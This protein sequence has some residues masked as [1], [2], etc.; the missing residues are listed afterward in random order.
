[1]AASVK[2][3]RMGLAADYLGMAVALV[4]LIAVFGVVAENFFTLTNFRT[5]ANQIPDVTVAAVGM[6]FVLIIAGIDLSVGSVLALSSAVLGMA[7]V[8][9]GLPLV[10][11]V[12]IC[13]LVLVTIGAISIP[14]L[15]IPFG[16]DF[17]F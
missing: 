14:F 1:M 15:C 10:P 12:G 13:L 6:T 11:A 7:L 8:N 17:N 2:K 3:R 5:I 9:W 16:N 4:V